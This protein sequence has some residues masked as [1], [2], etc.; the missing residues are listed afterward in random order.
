MV[1]L[2][3]F[4]KQLRAELTEVCACHSH[5]KMDPIPANA[6]SSI[7]MDCLRTAFVCCQ[8]CREASS[9]APFKRGCSADGLT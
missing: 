3:C 8:A 7:S 4:M 1:R 6:P 5:N 9:I 2:Q